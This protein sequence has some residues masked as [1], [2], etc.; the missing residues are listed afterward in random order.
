MNVSCPAPPQSGRTISVKKVLIGDLALIT[1]LW[2]ITIPIVDPIGDFPLNDDWSYGSTVKHFVETGDYRPIGWLSVPLVTNVIWGSLFCLPSGFSFTALRLSVLVLSWV[3]LLGTYALVREFHRSRR[4]AVIFT[5]SIAFNPIYYSLSYTFMTDV[6][7]VAIATWAAVFFVRGLKSE[8]ETQTVLGAVLGVAATLSR[9]IGIC[10]PLAFSVIVLV[11]NRPSLR[12]LL[13]AGIPVILCVGSYLL[14]SYWLETTGRLPKLYYVRFEWIRRML[15]D[16]RGI[17]TNFIA[18]ICAVV[19]Y[20][21]IF[22]LPTFL[23]SIK[24]LLWSAQVRSILATRRNA[25]ITLLAV[26]ILVL[27]L[28]A[29]GIVTHGL[30]SGTHSFL[31][32]LLGNIL[33]ESGV[34]P[35]FVE[36]PALPQGFWVTVTAMSLIGATLLLAKL[37]IHAV[38]LLQWSTWRRRFGNT[39]AATAFLILCGFIYLLPLLISGNFFD[40][41][42]LLAVV[43]LGAGTLGLSGKLSEFATG[44]SK[45]LRLSA[46]ALLLGFGVLSV[47][48]TRDYLTGNRV[49]W[50]SLWYLIR[51]NHVDP[52][53]IDGGFEFN[54]LYLYDPEYR[55]Q[56]RADDP[57]FTQPLRDPYC[58]PKA[59]ITGLWACRNTYQVGAD[60][61]SGYT[62]IKEDSYQHWLPPYIQRIVVL[63]K[64]SLRNE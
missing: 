54:G 28:G 37:S 64:N 27:V 35:S 52:R 44:L 39:E 16:P 36:G 13:R 59:A 23:F 29:R 15:T 50:E 1:V 51:A 30:S 34:G 47:C 43:L 61:V 46:F 2:C 10:I 63:R 49:R 19:I 53:D 17:Y 48:S 40:R 25:V 62:L 55:V 5:L 3:G 32:T 33:S 14:F 38:E 7:F 31:M 21:G 11:R 42:L 56:L 41:Y 8:S 12:I 4:V 18:A 57:E 24:D 26:E 20:L 45:P 22:L 9:Q 58:D 60:L 6:P